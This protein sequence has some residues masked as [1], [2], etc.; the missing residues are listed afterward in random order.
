[1]PHDLREEFENLIR[2]ANP[3][4]KDSLVEETVQLF[5]L[6]GV[7]SK[8]DLKYVTPAMFQSINM[9][10]IFERKIMEAIDTI[11]QGKLEH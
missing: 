3:T 9:P 7:R 11:T 6:E 1:L 2:K 4:I 8:Q 10:K 5:W